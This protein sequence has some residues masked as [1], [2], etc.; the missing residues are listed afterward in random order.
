MKYTHIE[1]SAPPCHS[2][3]QLYFSPPPN[4]TLS[5]ID[6]GL[7]WVVADVPSWLGINNMAVTAGEVELCVPFDRN[8][9]AS[10][11]EIY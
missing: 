5:T 3:Q 2:S 10:T 9:T 4:V 6:H 8:G 1:D 11:L 7:A